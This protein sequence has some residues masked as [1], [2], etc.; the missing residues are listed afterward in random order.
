MTIPK[1]CYYRAAPQV[2]QMCRLIYCGGHN[3]VYSL[4]FGDLFW[5]NTIM[6]CLKRH[7]VTDL[8]HLMLNIWELLE[9]HKYLC[10]FWS[11]QAN[12]TP[13]VMIYRDTS[14]CLVT[15]FKE[16]LSCFISK[17]F[18]GCFVQPNGSNWRVINK[19]LIFCVFSGQNIGVWPPVVVIQR[20]TPY[21]GG[22]HFEDI[23]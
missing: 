22:I 18:C 1:T 3:E 17:V 19:T 16:T 15:N 14:Y 4:L 5:I 11:K 9:K 23:L 20:K 8:H 7:N 10:H 21:F 6:I 12:V 13:G 2:C